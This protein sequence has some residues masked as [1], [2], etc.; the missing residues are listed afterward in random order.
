MY[1]L[2]KKFGCDWSV[3]R[4]AIVADPFIPNRYSDPIHKS[5][6][7]AGGHCFIKDFEAFKDLYE[8]I[9]PDDKNS[10][11]ILEGNIKKNIELLLSTKKDV[12]LLRGVYGDDIINI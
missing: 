1:D 12:G 3:I 10:V 6:R 2:A 11:S 8:K 4:K 5:G 7:G 9:L